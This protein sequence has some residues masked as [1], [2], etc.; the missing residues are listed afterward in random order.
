MSLVVLD[1]G[2]LIAS[3]FPETLTA[4]AQHLIKQLQSDGIQLHAPTLLRYEVIAV[5]RK[6]VYQGQV[7]VEEGLRARDRL[8]SYPVTLHLDDALLKRSYELATQYNS[9]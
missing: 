2:I 1:S 5:S 8:L 7:T 4:Q 9:V 6:A 3:V